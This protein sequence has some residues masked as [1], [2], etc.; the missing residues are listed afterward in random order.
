MNGYHFARAL[1]G[2][3]S[4]VTFYFVCTTIVV[5]ASCKED[6]VNAVVYDPTPFLLEFGGFPP[7]PL[8]ADLVLTEA[9][10]ALGSM[11]FHET[12][13]SGDLTQ[14]C[15]SCHQQEFGFSDPNTFSIGIDGLPG[16]RQ[17]MT[18]AN[19]AWHRNG[20][21][22]DGRS[23]TLR[24]Q[25]L[26]P[27]QDPLEMHETLDNAIAKLRDKPEYA[28]AF[29]RAFGDE[30]ISADRIGLALEQFMIT[31]IS[32]DSR[33]DRY[34]RGELLLTESEARGL[35][36]FNTEFDP[37]GV[38]KGAECFHCH[39]G[40]NF[41]N[42]RFSNNGLDAGPPFADE[43]RYEVTGN[44]G[45]RGKF[46]VPTLRNIAQTAPYMHD[47]RFATL[48]EVIDHYDHGVQASP[49]VDPL[50]Q[51]SIDPG[52]QLSEQDK[53]DLEAFLRTLSDEAFLGL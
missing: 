10:V 34:Q 16:R 46:L 53:L 39:G 52:L 11:L 49:T 8:P 45:D 4:S 30:D 21:F 37:L 19:L 12:A 13:L 40:F 6:P 15:A 28:D 48:R 9:G 43:G 38:V 7:P 33:F 24:D 23:P 18:L 31:L 36:L 22:W 51:F 50:L 3:A 41:T 29:V 17:A 44:P 27:I 35:A 42:D 1:G 5:L 25:A 47:G 14:S 32:N 26:R 2:W 20:F